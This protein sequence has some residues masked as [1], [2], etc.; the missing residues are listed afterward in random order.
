MIGPPS[1]SGYVSGHF[2]IAKK[3]KRVYITHLPSGGGLFD[4]RT[5]A[6]AKAAVLELLTLEQIEWT[7][8][9]PVLPEGQLPAFR[10]ITRKYA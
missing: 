5:F 9:N 10:A 2:G 3:L 8:N 6:L 1:L 4:A 7:S